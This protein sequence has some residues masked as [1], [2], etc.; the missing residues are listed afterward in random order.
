M[1]LCAKMAV[2]DLVVNRIVD[3]CATR[4]RPRVWS[5]DPALAFVATLVLT[6][7]RRLTSDDGV[8]RRH[9]RLRDDRTVLVETLA[10][11]C[12]LAGPKTGNVR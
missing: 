6:R 5:I 1:D 8:G 2:N 9:L 12:G 7:T 3:L 4:C 11:S 10:R